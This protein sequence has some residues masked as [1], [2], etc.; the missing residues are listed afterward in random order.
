[1]ADEWH[2]AGKAGNHGVMRRP[3]FDPVDGIPFA[4]HAQ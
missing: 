4:D 3:L 2:E 1:M